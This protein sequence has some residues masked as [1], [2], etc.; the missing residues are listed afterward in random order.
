MRKTVSLAIA[1]ATLAVAAP[2]SAHASLMEARV[3][4]LANAA[5]GFA[6]RAGA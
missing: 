4:L 3:P 6:Q 2:A 1:A 5:W